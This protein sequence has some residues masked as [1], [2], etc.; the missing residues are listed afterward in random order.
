MPELDFISGAELA[1]ASK[2]ARPYA[3]LAMHAIATNPSARRLFSA[4]IAARLPT[5]MLGIGLLVHAQHLTGS[6]AA[7]GI[8][9]AALAAALGVGGPLLG[10]VVDRRGQTAVLMTGALVA[11]VALAALATLPT[12]TPLPVI[13]ALAAVLGLG[14]PPVAA[15][16]RT[17]IPVLLRDA[18][19]VRA[20]YAA[21][22]A[23]VELT[24]I[25]GPPL[26]LTLG[27]LLSTGLALAVAGAILVV[28]T[29]VFAAQPAS[30]QW[31]PE[32]GRERPRGGSLRAPA[33]RTLLSVEV[34]LGFLFGAVEVAV[35]A[36]AQ[37]LGAK[38]AVGPLLGVWGVG[39]L[40]GGIVA[41]R[42]GGGARTGAGLAL[43]LAVL[44]A[45]HLALAAAAESVVALGVGLGLAGT[46]I[47]PTFATVYAMVDDAAPAGTVTEAFAWLSTA[48]AVGGAIGSAV[49]GAVAQGAG[50]APTF[51]L[52]AAAGA[53]AAIMVALRTCR[54]T[55]RPALAAA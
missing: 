7:A 26:V 9:A 14:N 24:W 13:V 37:A 15:A 32:P 27:A 12:G 19:A 34:A 10:R 48:G 1:L 4:S 22:S 35:V 36:A 51:V 44:T 45:A 46:M 53:G 3:G 21:E 40:V 55:P 16:T 2:P 5:V 17:L 30:R 42:A 11:G 43:I 50:P 29:A 39:S 6:F 20:A 28:A 49:A 8:V 31:R 52:A 25:A 38:A 18:D 41:T 47:A 33:M 23:A 54:L